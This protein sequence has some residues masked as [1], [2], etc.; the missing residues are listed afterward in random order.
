MNKE[1]EKVKEVVKALCKHMEEIV[2]PSETAD[3]IISLVLA[4]G[5]RSREQVMLILS[6]FAVKAIDI[7]K[8]TPDVIKEFVKNRD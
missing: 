7:H 5:Y 3:Q 2:D 4:E 6:S 8:S 1:H